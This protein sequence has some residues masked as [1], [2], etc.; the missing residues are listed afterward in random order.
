MEDEETIVPEDMIEALKHI[1]VDIATG[2]AHREEGK[3][4]LTGSVNS[5]AFT[6]RIQDADQYD[7]DRKFR[8]MVEDEKVNEYESA[9][10][11]MERRIERG[12]DPFA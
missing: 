11:E 6:P 1:G 5:L 3:L 2:F 10:E 8:I 9:R 4:L 12:E 7:M